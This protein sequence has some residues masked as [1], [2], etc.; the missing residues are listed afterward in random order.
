MDKKD[1]EFFKR[2]QATFRVE[3]EEHIREL[4]SGLI[5]LEKAPKFEKA[6]ELI[7]AIFR[8]AHSL[9]GAARSV[10]MKEIESI[11]Q[12]LEN[13]F[14]KIKNEHIS[15]S[16]E[17]FD[18]IYKAVDSIS[19]MVSDGGTIAPKDNR[20]L[21]NQL[22]SIIQTH[23]QRKIVDEQ[24]ESLKNPLKEATTG[25]S[26][27]NEIPVATERFIGEKPIQA[28]TVRIPIS[29]LDPLF[30]QA[31]QMIQ[32]KIA[33]I[34]RSSE[35]K[36]I[37]GLIGLWK[38]EQKKWDSPRY[39]E[40]ITGLK[41]INDWNNERLKELETHIIAVTHALETDQRSLGRMIDDH[42]ESMKSVLML[43]VSTITEGFPKFV[44]DLARSQG[45]EAE[46]V[47]QGKEIEVDKRILEELKDPLI[48]LIRNCIDHGIKKP[49]ERECLNKLPQ[50]K[51]TMSFNATESRHLEIRISDDGVGI[52]PENVRKAAIKTGI[53]DKGSLEKLNP[54]ETLM[55][56]FQSGFSTSQMITDIS[57]RGL[58]LAIVK[59]K[60]E[61]LGGSVSVE[62][63]P[64]VGTTFHLLLPLTLATFRGIL[65]RIGNHWV[66][67]P[68]INVERAVRVNQKEIK[69]V[70]SR[71]T[72]LIDGKILKTVRLGN[73][74]GITTGGNGTPTKKNHS[75]KH[76]TFI[77]LLILVYAD[78]R[79]AFIV[80]E[81]IEECQ[82]LV[83]ELGKQLTRV[84]NISGATVLGSGKV[85]PVINVSDLMK[86]ATQTDLSIKESKEKEIETVMKSKILVID[87][88]ITSRTLIKNILESAGYLIET[89]VDGVDA[90]TKTQI[91]GFDLIVSDI[92]MPRMNGFELTAK[93][94]KDK[95]LCDLPIV[96]VTALESREDRERGIDVGANAYIV[97]SSFDQSNLLEV[98]KKLL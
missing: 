6:S 52:E 30:L 36:D 93:I 18:L 80:D 54:N 64:G 78:K 60:V 81:I 16:A 13:I 15:L 1:E 49:G 11:C 88:S 21:I 71:E 23:A 45:K 19:K 26:F 48:H 53:L 69:T 43:P 75:T 62:S 82:I 61:K 4:T 97:K 79:I 96:L 32:Y 37:N 25:A 63:S 12:V 8:E 35:M 65:T 39:S 86:S 90:F 91:G 85:V 27:E 94:R 84:W 5:E 24:T 17:Q 59:E 41:K 29:K 95:K 55:L 76:D 14:G 98:I 87:D 89:A 77:Q 46:L 10:N 28:G 70:E 47:V 67:I 7:E 3:A 57:G 58:G 34:Q 68:T 20:G 22:Q 72:I 74:L 51:I 66:V 50:G 9:K 40:S 2:L 56:V 83:K 44:R 73:V 33:A 38:T 92:D 31:E 42:L